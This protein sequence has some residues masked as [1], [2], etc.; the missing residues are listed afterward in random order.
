MKQ[1]CTSKAL[2]ARKLGASR[3]TLYY[4]RKLPVRDWSLKVRIEEALR[5]HPSYGSR[6]I[7]IHLKRN[8]KPIARVMKLFGIK[9]YRRRGRK[10][11][12]RKVFVRYANLLL[13]TMPAYPGHI[14]AADFTEI[15]WREK[16]IYLATVIDLYTREILGLS[17]S[18]H[19][20][21][22]LT[23]AALGN[24]LLS[25]PRP[26]IFHSDNGSEYNAGV[27]LSAL[28]EIGTSISR[29]KPGCPW[30]NGYQESFYN[31]FKIDLGD[32]NRFRTFGELIAEIYA[33]IWAYN[34]TRIHSA[35]RMPPAQFAFQ[36]EK[37]HTIH[38]K[39]GV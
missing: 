16:K 23:L 13:T 9:A 34:H 31:Q 22:Q 11:R 25:H 39:V 8:R 7:A 2:R 3:G 35:L 24:A 27:F 19:K 36:A 6:R 38:Y 32:S 14:W 4:Q 18:M 30:E 10:Y 37:R 20:G 12:S 29:S 33:A 26:T 17:I 1:S 15:W 5:E 21:A 28:E